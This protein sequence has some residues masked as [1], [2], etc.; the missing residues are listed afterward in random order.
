[1]SFA[2]CTVSGRAI[3]GTVESYE[4]KGNDNLMLQSNAAQAD[5]GLTK[6]CSEGKAHLPDFSDELP[7]ARHYRIGLTML[8]LGR[9]AE[10]EKYLRTF[11]QS[12]EAKGS[13]GRFQSKALNAVQATIVCDD[14]GKTRGSSVGPEPPPPDVIDLWGRRR[15]FRC[16]LRPT[17]A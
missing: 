11:E 8:D 4:I 7:V 9:L 2:F 10:L 15:R 12:L 13:I 14:V 5:M 1:M 6:D 16:S 17:Q 3:P